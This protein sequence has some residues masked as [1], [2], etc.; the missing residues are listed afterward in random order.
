MVARRYVRMPYLPIVTYHR[1][2]VP[3]ID[4]KELDDSVVD[5]TKEDFDRQV[6]LMTK[7][8]TVLGV[9]ELR[10]FF[11]EGRP[12]PKNPVLITFDDGYK[13]CYDIA[14][15]ILKKYGTKAIFFISTGHMNDRKAFWWDRANY[16]V[17]RT[18]K[19][20][21]E[22]EYPKHAVYE[23]NGDRSKAL[24]RIL[25]VIKMTFGMDV[26]RY[27]QE[28]SKATDVPW[29]EADDKRITD[30]VL[31]T[32]DQVRA[33]H[34]AGMD[35]ESHTHTHR[36]LTTLPAD[37][38]EAE[39]VGSK[40]LLEEKIDAPVRALAYP[41]S[42]SMAENGHILEAVRKARYELGF[43][44]SSGLGPLG[45]RTDPLDIQRIWVDPTLPHSYFRAALAVP[46]LT[47]RRR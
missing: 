9:E 26:E 19:T 17:K 44:T 39:L 45:P 33:M 47:Y 30:D 21:I 38:L 8:F 42:L 31:M 27:L 11:F 22:L 3:A 20:R 14:L 15:P 25:D 28:L 41:V 5:A 23:L 32:W 7:R 37:E 12:L 35:V 4:A 34:R 36:V 2:G 24:T 13:A 29:T 43:S 10:Q 46:H 16:L 18:K 1:L 6:A 40:R